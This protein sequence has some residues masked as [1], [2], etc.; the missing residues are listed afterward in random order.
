MA[1]RLRYKLRADHSGDQDP[2]LGADLLGQFRG[3]MDQAESTLE[4]CYHGQFSSLA[5]YVEE[6][7]TDSGTIPEALRYYVDWD[8]VARDAENHLA[9]PACPARCW[10]AS[11]PSRFSASAGR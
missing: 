11:G 8:A 1:R 10:Q 5:N 4:D 7:T 3:D 9:S 6:L 2:C